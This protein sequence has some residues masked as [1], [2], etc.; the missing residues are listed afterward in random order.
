MQAFPVPAVRRLLAIPEVLAQVAEETWSSKSLAALARTCR[1]F[2][3]PALDKLWQHQPGLENI[4]KCMPADLWEMQP[5]HDDDGS[6]TIIFQRPLRPEDW[7]RFDVYALRIRE[8][9]IGFR[10][11]YYEV[12]RPKLSSE[13]LVTLDQYNPSKA[14]FPNLRYLYLSSITDTDVVPYRRLFLSP[15]LLDLVI[16]WEVFDVNAAALLDHLS[17]HC[18]SVRI[19]NIATQQ[20]ESWSSPGPVEIRAGI[21]DS[22]KALHI[23]SFIS[24]VPLPAAAFMEL[25]SLP[26]LTDL[27]ISILDEPASPWTFPV[28]TEFRPFRA[29]QLFFIRCS[30]VTDCSKVLAAFSFPVLEGL[31]IRAGEFGSLGHL[32][33]IIRDNCSHTSLCHISI[34][35][36]DLFDQD[37]GPVEAT[38]SDFRNLYAFH[39]LQV[40]SVET[41]NEIRLTDDDLRDMALSWPYL[42]S[43]KLLPSKDKERPPETIRHCPRLHTLHIGID[44]SQADAA[45]IIE[46]L[47]GAGP[48]RDP[49]EVAMSLAIIFRRLEKFIGGYP[50]ENSPEWKPTELLLPACASYVASH[51]VYVESPH[52]E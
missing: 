45:R 6:S 5:T 32:F 26:H 1:D 51:T 44:T 15:A 48:M 34:C 43:L 16:E 10:R 46:A 13:A 8:L 19:L 35:W 21:F 33:R 41:F 17:A 39:E 7:V 40:L 24:A 22:L 2:C 36:C 9:C 42:E 23:L 30:Q 3:S 14:L 28:A 25:Q 12:G 37:P 4:V 20:E 52:S 27:H 38:A 18:Q 49:N 50:Q 11:L 31:T 29:L 47:S